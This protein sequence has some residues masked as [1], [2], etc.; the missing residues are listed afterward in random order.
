MFDSGSA[1]RQF[2]LVVLTSITGLPWAKAGL[3]G[4]H[5]SK[6]RHGKLEWTDPTFHAF[7]HSQLRSCESCSAERA[8]VHQISNTDKGKR[9]ST[10]G[11][12]WKIIAPSLQDA[13]QLANKQISCPSPDTRERRTNARE[14]R[15]ICGNSD[16]HAVLHSSVKRASRRTERRSWPR[17]AKPTVLVITSGLD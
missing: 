5:R 15:R 6:Q 13:L 9:Q 12:R 14:R 10:M 3:W 7:Q 16:L 11:R 17:L 4:V 8:M 1:G 2:L